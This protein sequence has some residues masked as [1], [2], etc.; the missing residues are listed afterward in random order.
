MMKIITT[1]V[2]FLFVITVYAQSKIEVEKRIK[3][4]LV[5]QNAKDFIDQIQ[6]KKQLKWVK[7]IS[8]E[9]IH[10]EAKFIKNNR[11]SV[12]FD[13]T[14]KLIDV[15]I[16]RSKKVHQQKFKLL[17]EKELKTTQ[18]IILKIQEQW[19]A[20]EDLL[21]KALNTELI[22]DSIQSNHEIE[23]KVKTESGVKYYEFLFD[24]NKHLLR[25]RTIKQ[26]NTDNLIY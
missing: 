21:V 22:N 12:E 5:P 9:G 23:V 13:E 15:E 16:L 24:E 8:D 4:Y 14:G 2:C 1:S 26:P 11:I 6:N 7:E 19:L 17:I 20:E 25:N 3:S 10:Y 18:F